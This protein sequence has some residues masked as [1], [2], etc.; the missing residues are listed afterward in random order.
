MNHTKRLEF[1]LNAKNMK[2]SQIMYSVMNVWMKRDENG[3]IQNTRRG[4]QTARLKREKQVGY[5]RDVVR[6]TLQMGN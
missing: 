4:K 6:G 2:R 3:V 5:A 1:V